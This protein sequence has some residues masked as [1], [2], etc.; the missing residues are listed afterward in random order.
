MRR[1][2]GHRAVAALVVS[3]VVAGTAYAQLAITSNNAP[4]NGPIPVNQVGRIV[5]SIRNTSASPIDIVSFTQQM[6]L[7]AIPTGCQ[8]ITLSRLD[9]PGMQAKT[10]APNEQQQYIATVSPGFATP[11]TYNCTWDIATNPAMAPAPTVTTSYQVSATPGVIDVQPPV[12]D[13][14]SQTSPAFEIQQVLVTNYGS[15][16]PAMMQ[17][18]GDAGSNLSFT[19]ACSGHTCFTTIGGAGSSGGVG[20]KC[21]PNSTM[22]AMAQLE[23]TTMPGSGSGSTMPVNGIGSA[24]ISCD[25]FVGSQIRIVENPIAITAPLGQVGSGSATVVAM[26]GSASLQNAFISGGD[27]TFKISNCGAQ[28]CTFPAIPTPTSLT[29]ECQTAAAPKNATLTV[30]EPG[31][32]SD[33][34]PIVCTSSGGGPMLLV[35]PGS[36]DYGTVPVGGT[37]VFMFELRNMGG[38]PLTGVALSFPG[39]QGSHWNASSCTP[40]APCTIAPGTSTFTTVTFAPT[41]H[42]DRSTNMQ[43]TSN[44]PASPAFVSLMGVGTGGVMVVTAPSGPP[45]DLDLGTIPLGQA[46]SRTV[47]IANSGNAGITAQITGA[48]PPYTITPSSDFITSTPKSFTVTCQSNTASANNDQTLTITSD[49]YMGSPQ[50]LDVHCTVADTLVQVMPNSFDFGEVRVGS[51]TQRLTVTVT[52]PASATAAAHVF[53]IGLRDPRNGLALVPASTDVTLQPGD[54][55]SA[56]LELSTATDTDLTG[57]F[58]DIHV[59]G[60]MLALPVGGKVVTPHSRVVPAELDLGTACVGTQVSG[61]VMLINDGT[62]TL[63]VDPPQM[64]GSFLASSPPGTTFPL[65][66]SPMS[67]TSASVAP[68]MSATGPID[69]TLTWHDD[70][71]NDFEIPVKLDFVSSG[72]ALSPAALDFGTVAVDAAAFP[73]HITLENCDLAPTKITI[74]AINTKKGAVGAWVLEPRLG[75]EKTLQAHDKQG[76]TVTFRPPARGQYEANLEVVTDAG[77]RTIHLNGAATGRDFDNTSFYACACSGSG[78]PSRGWPIALA[79]VAIFRRRRAPSSAR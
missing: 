36:H 45:Y 71:P 34:K 4:T 79:F 73:Q 53:S 75:Y 68:A 43:I 26:M 13:F 1:R 20:I 21:Q 58:L 48:S 7:A 35:V 9:M 27:A 60:A 49:A 19:G 65:S 66:L 37:S 69:G 40:A 30:V 23:V 28:N 29:V 8:G 14:G 6:L 41:A 39:P 72:T 76:I 54:S 77:P 62:A 42:G 3:A 56:T 24:A 70:T 15:G 12:M 16:A 57:E 44:D 11:G 17:I 59:D 52:N 61:T 47:T 38:A 78:A 18:V 55:A 63:E 46:F 32:G 50:S 5:F 74:K 64:D 31:G 10:L 33:F 2:P 25:T 67:S 51:P 22:A